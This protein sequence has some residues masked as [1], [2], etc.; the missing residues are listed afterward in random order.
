MSKKNKIVYNNDYGGFNLSDEAVKWLEQNAT[1]EN[2]RE[3]LKKTR[4][5]QVKAR[6]KNKTAYWGTVE[7]SMGFRLMNSFNENGLPRHHK[8]LVAVVETLGMDASG[9]YSKLDICELE[10]YVYRIDEYDGWETVVTPE[11]YNWTVIED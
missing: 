1:D 8:D 9:N 6:E 3:F 2:V 4:V 5:E 11:T 7:S 10:S